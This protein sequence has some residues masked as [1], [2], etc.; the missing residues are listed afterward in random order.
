MLRISLSKMADDEWVDLES[1][2]STESIGWRIYGQRM[3]DTFEKTRGC[4]FWRCSRTAIYPQ[5]R[6]GWSQIVG[7]MPNLLVRL[8]NVALGLSIS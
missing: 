5:Q 8:Q 1:R 7:M 4:S 3:E 2:R 6:G